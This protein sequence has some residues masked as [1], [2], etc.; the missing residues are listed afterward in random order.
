MMRVHA[1]EGGFTLI[2]LLIG[3]AIF[4]LLATACYKL[5]TSAITAR[6]VTSV[7]WNH[8]RHLQKTRLIMQKDINQ[9]I[10]R[11]VRDASGTTQFAFIG[12]NNTAQESTI[13]AT[14]TH[15]GWY[16]FLGAPRS[17]LQR[18]LYAVEAN[19]LIRYYWPLLDLGPDTTPIRQVLLNDITSA[20]IKFLDQKKRWVESW[21][22]ASEQENLRFFMLPLAVQFSFEQHNKGKIQWIFQ[23]IH[24]VNE[25]EIPPK[26]VSSDNTTPHSNNNPY[27]SPY[28]YHNSN[29]DGPFA[30]PS[31]SDHQY[32]NGNLYGR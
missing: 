14:L 10:P 32:N 4:S 20:S 5:L 21:P 12:G 29:A 28:N 6:D 7:V 26:P 25:T 11:P 15:A 8:L 27:A 16:N 1:K 3:I 13:L 2:E 31:W 23:G 18:V 22:P 17:D 19:Q 30:H 9:M 24:F